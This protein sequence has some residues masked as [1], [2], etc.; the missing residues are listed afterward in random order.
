MC[1][2]VGMAS[3]DS[4]TA[5]LVLGSD[6]TN[7]GFLPDRSVQGVVNSLVR[8]MILSGLGL[9]VGLGRSSFA[10]HLP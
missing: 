4:I 6:L 2:L 10:M 8:E 3:A 7:W 9:G 5:A 1:D